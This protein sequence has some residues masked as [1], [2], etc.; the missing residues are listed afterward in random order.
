MDFFVLFFN[1]FF[2]SLTFVVKLIENFQ[3]IKSSLNLAKGT[4]PV[5]QGREFFKVFLCF[6]RV[7]PE[8]GFMC[9][10]FFFFN[11]G[12]FLIDVKDTPSAP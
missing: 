12:I 1:F 10:F 7:V 2:S 11:N 6:R 4:G 3:I 9:F 5:F 8:T